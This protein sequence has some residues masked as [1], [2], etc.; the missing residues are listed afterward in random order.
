MR[1]FLLLE[2]CALGQQQVDRSCK[3]ELYIT[4][5]KYQWPHFQ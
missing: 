2:K 4:F 3:G 1:P 5:T